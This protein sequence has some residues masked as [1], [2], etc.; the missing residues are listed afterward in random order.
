MVG[1]NYARKKDVLKLLISILV[2]LILVSIKS[3][4]HCQVCPLLFRGSCSLVVS[5]VLWYERQKKTGAGFCLE[6]GP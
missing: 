6:Y 5:A 3:R 2:N 1:M 4:G